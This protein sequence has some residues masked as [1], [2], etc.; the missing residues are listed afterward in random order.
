MFVGWLEPIKNIT[1]LLI[2]IKKLE[3]LLPNK[4]VNL[5]IVGDGTELKFLKK[6]SKELNLNI[7]FH[8]WIKNRIKL[9]KIYS[10]S[11]C[12]CLTS[13]NE[14]FPNV[15]LEAMSNGLPIISTKVGAL[16]F[17]LKEGRNIL[18]SEENDSLSFA[19]NIKKLFSSKNLFN[20]ISKNNFEDAVNKFNCDVIAS[21]LKII[22]DQ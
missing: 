22:L 13:K 5:H 11:D 10:S 1:F 3:Y 7:T 19:K 12:F 16:P 4:N 6:R 9:D 20:I 8:G 21:E 15:V 18:F 17:W 14:G 2:A